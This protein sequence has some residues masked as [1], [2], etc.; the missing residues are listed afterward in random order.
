VVRTTTGW[1]VLE[2]E[3]GHATFAPMSE[4]SGIADQLRGR[5]GHVSWERVLSGRGW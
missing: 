4:R 3:G 2:G 5:F 1:A